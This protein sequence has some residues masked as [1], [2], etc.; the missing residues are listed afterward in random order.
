MCVCSLA[1]VAA[2]ERPELLLKK[3]QQCCVCFDFNDVFSDLP[4]KEV[5]RQT[6]VEL[7]D[8][9]ST[10]RGVITDALYP[11]LVKMV[12]LFPLLIPTHLLSP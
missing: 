9:I 11:E 8:H 1:E 7:V 4:G 2:A 5:K 6:L 3:I 10:S 12:G